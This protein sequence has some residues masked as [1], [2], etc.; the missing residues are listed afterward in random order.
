MGVLVFESQTGESPVS[1]PPRE[2]ELVSVNSLGGLAHQ[3]TGTTLYGRPEGVSPIRCGTGS[4]GG[5]PRA[6][7]ESNASGQRHRDCHPDG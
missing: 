4:P 5:T 7:R 3:R 6:H 1:L 2:Q